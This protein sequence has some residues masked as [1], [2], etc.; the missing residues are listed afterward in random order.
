[1]TQDL[2]AF[3]SRFQ[4]GVEVAVASTSSD[5][6]LGI[7]DGFHRY[8][9]DALDRRISVVVVPHAET[10]DLGGLSFTDAGTVAM[11]RSRARSLIDSLGEAYHF[12]VG[13]E[14]GLHSLEFDGET[15][16]FVR[17]WTAVVGAIGEAWGAS[18]S[19]EVPGRYIS[20]AEGREAPIAIPGTRRR[21]GMISSLTAGLETRRSAV[22]EATF[23]ALS[24]LFYGVLEGN[25]RAGV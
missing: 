15:H 25:P 18:G 14:G 21:G 6:L 10:E 7:R 3:W 12:Y 23:H 11:A 5:K 16:Y 2:R 17:N 20:G 24:S 13:S 4:T 9:H 19:I 1:M 22:S 8:F